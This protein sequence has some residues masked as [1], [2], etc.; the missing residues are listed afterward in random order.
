M[1][2]TRIAS[3][4]RPALGDLTARA[5]L[6]AARRRVLEVV[7]ASDEAMTAVQVASALNLHHNTVREHLDSLVDAGFVTISTRPTGKRGRPALRYSSTAPDPRQV[8]ES[9]LTLLDAVA[10]ILGEGEEAE[11]TALAI[12]QRWAELSPSVLDVAAAF[13]AT[14]KERM[15]ALLP[16]LA[17]MGFAPEVKDDEIVLRTCPLVSHGHNPHPLVCA[18]HEGFLRAVTYDDGNRQAVA[19]N[20]DIVTPVRIIRPT[21]NGC[22]LDLSAANEL[23]GATDTAGAEAPANGEDAE[24]PLDD[25]AVARA[26]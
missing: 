1:H 13:D 16:H 19:C 20:G 23:A 3:F 10:Q 25:P 7:E 8:I 6:S 26:S 12:G 18:M 24:G 9:Y 15:S 22:R 11:A 2:N 14:T 21:A 17:M 4:P 5:D